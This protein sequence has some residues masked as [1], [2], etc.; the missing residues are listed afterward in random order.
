MKR[1]ISPRSS[2]IKVTIQVVVLLV[3]CLLKIIQ[4][5]T[6]EVLRF[7]YCSSILLLLHSYVHRYLPVFPMRDEMVRSQWKL[8]MLPHSTQAASCLTNH[9]GMV[10]PRIFLSL[11]A[12]SW[13]NFHRIP[14]EA[15][16]RNH[17]WHPCT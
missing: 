5:T 17:M 1:N 14:A 4:S 2:Q 8:A 13:Y 10:G 11:R 16:I 15:Q 6:Q 7:A 12:N 3:R 9:E